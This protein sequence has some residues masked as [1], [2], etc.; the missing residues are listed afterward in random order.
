MGRKFFAIFGVIHKLGGAQFALFDH[1]RGTKGTGVPEGTEGYDG[2]EA[3]N[4]A[5]TKV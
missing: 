4:D 3:R 1:T 2:G 5:S